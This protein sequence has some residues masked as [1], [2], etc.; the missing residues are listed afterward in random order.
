MIIDLHVHTIKYS[1]CSLIDP[2]DAVSM[3]KK[4]GMD[5]ICITEHNAIWSREETEQLSEIHNFL[6]L[7][8][9]EVTTRE[10]H[11]LVFGLDSFDKKMKNLETLRLIAKNENAVMFAAHPFRRPI[12]PQRGYGDWELTIPV[13]LAANRRIFNFVDGLEVFSNR[14]E[15]EESLISLK[16]GQ[17][18]NL[19]TIAGSDAHEFKKVGSSATVFPCNITDESNFI[20]AL[21]DEYYYGIDIGY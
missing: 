14:S 1:K 17:Y 2:D 8:G 13:E 19:K 9:I 10:G 4:H 12:Y 20:E 16:V 5:A 6:I 21:R 11:I 18:R 15:P 7:R 3:A